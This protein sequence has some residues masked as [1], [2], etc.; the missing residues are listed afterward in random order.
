MKLLTK[1]IRRKLPPLYSQ[2]GKGGQ[3]IAQVKFFTPDS[4]WTFYATEFDGEDRFFGL[5]DG[6]DKELGYFSLAELQRI[7]GPLGLPI[8][9]DLYWQP[10]PLDEIVPE[11]FK[12]AGHQS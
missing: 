10:K 7:R 4:S 1:A 2:D 6:D 12:P 9:R 8:E 5:V 3:A 11:L